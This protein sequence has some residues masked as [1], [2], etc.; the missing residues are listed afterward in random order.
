MILGATY[1]W[2]LGSGGTVVD[3]GGQV[4]RTTVHRAHG[5]SHECYHT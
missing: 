5:A 3:L 4:E 2:L 1:V